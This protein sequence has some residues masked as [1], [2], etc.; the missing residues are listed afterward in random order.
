MTDETTRDQ[1]EATE[2]GVAG[3]DVA[4]TG[5]TAAGP[6]RRGQHRRSAARR[7]R[8]PGR[9]RLRRAVVLVAYLVAIAALAGFGWHDRTVSAEEDAREEALTAAGESVEQ[10]L[11]YDYRAIE[12]DIDAAKELTTGALREQY[13]KTAPSLLSQARQVRA[14]VQASVGSAGVMSVSDDRVVVLL[15]VDQATVKQVGAATEPTTRIDQNRIRVTMSKV[16]DR[17]LVS[18]LA[19]L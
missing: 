8:T 11:S 3:T 14:I 12:E 7:P 15:F 13:D 10:I 9:R 2:T 1:P 4:G 18:E 17:W 6:R 19:A 5:V 16:D